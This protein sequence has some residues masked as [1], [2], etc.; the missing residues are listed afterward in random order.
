MFAT[1]Y[2]H[3]DQVRFQI[4]D[5]AQVSVGTSATGL[6]DIPTGDVR[7]EIKRVIIRPVDGDIFWN[8]LGGNPADG[9]GFPAPKMEIMVYDGNDLESF[10]MAAAAG[11]VDVRIIYLC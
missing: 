10:K 3:G 4:W 8:G 1:P 6:P 2:L 5:H 9:T 11:T 7:K